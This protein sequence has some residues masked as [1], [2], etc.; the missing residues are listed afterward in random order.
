ME[1]P[2]ECIVLLNDTQYAGS[3][4]M[5]YV[6]CKLKVKEYA[7]VKCVRGLTLGEYRVPSFRKKH[8]INHT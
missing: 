7:V 3:K 4:T 1:T 2:T 5:P 6:E 8:T